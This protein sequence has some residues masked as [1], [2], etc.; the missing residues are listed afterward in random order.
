[1]REKHQILPRGIKKSVPFLREAH[2]T[3]KLSDP[4]DFHEFFILALKI[5]LNELYGILYV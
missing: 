2:E 4:F 1:M 5:L 3:I